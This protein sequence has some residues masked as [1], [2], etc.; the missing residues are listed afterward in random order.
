MFIILS[1]FVFSRSQKKK[2]KKLKLRSKKKKQ[3]HQQ[4]IYLMFDNKYIYNKEISFFF[5]KFL[6]FFYLCLKFLSLFN[7]I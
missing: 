4:C 7:P 5:L 2:L 6:S 3:I 1:D